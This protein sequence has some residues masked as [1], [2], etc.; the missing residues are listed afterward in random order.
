MNDHRLPL[1]SCVVPCGFPSPADDYV[2]T[3]LDLNE[4]VIA[5]PAATFYIRVSGDS[6][7]QA[8]ISPGDILVV[9]RALS[10]QHHDIVVA[11][12]DGEFTVKRLHRNGEITSLLPANPAYAP[13]RVTEAMQ[14]QVWGVVTYCLHR[15]K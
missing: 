8:G 6:M 4:L 5:H 14:F 15:V 12:L 13:I 3:S 9:D 1:F 7:N 2:E 10:P 11:L